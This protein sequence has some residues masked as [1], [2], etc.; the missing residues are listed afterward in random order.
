[1]STTEQLNI[2]AFS[3]IHFI[4]DTTGKLFNDFK[5]DLNEYKSA[6]NSIDIIVYCGDISRNK[7]F[8]DDG[9][10]QFIQVFNYIYKNITKPIYILLGNND[11]NKIIY[12][13]LT[14]LQSTIQFKAMFIMHCKTPTDKPRGTLAKGFLQFHDGAFFETVKGRHILF[15]SF[16]QSG[17]NKNGMT[18]NDHEE[19]TKNLKTAE[20]IFTH[21]TFFEM[22]NYSQKLY[23][24]GHHHLHPKIGLSHWSEI[25]HLKQTA[26]YVETEWPLF[27]FEYKSSSYINVSIAHTDQSYTK[28]FNDI[29]NRRVFPTL[30]TING[31]P[32]TMPGTPLTMP[33]IE[34]QPKN[35]FDID[36]SNPFRINED[37]VMFY[38]EDT[39]PLKPVI[40]VIKKSP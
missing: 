35:T 28:K 14:S 38:K 17:D 7:D 22:K 20:I 11:L 27:Y 40:H 21:G 37:Y 10:K 2:L 31:N 19:L 1:M 32:L 16:S 5:E 6:F 23:I 33:G 29:N 9:A 3:D 12:N 4:G 30:I 25:E 34:E 36:K 26:S 18:E 39:L 8:N 13:Q 24:F 15:S